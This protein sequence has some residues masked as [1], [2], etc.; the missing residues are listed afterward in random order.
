MPIEESTFASQKFEPKGKAKG[1][2][3]SLIL[4]FLRANPNKAFTQKEIWEQ[5]GIKYL[6]S[7]NS[8][9]HALKQSNKVQCRVVN[10]YLYWRIGNAE[11]EK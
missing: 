9:L 3:Q 6:P 2:N 5:T 7:V 10:G 11:G 1:S 4:H 8:A